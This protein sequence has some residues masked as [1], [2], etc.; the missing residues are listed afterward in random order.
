MRAGDILMV[1]AAG[2]LRIET[3]DGIRIDSARARAPCGCQADSHA[4]G[5]STCNRA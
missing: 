5:C 3:D 1:D 4:P 2:F